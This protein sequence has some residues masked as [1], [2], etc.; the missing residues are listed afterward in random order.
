MGEKRTGLLQLGEEVTFEARHLG[1]R[2]RLTSRITEFD[3]PNRFVDEMVRGPFKKLRHVHFFEQMS[4]GT[5]VVD[6]MEFS[7]PLG[8][9]GNLV[10]SRLVEGHL[11]RFLIARNGF[12]KGILESE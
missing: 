4:D 10:A 7:L 9:L 1:S 3:R 6:E 8:L 5:I 11:N 2:F 12:M